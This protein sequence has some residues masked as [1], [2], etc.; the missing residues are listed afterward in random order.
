[1]EDLKK[2]LLEVLRNAF[3]DEFTSRQIGSDLDKVF[4]KG[5]AGGVITAGV[6]MGLIT[7]DEWKELREE[8]KESLKK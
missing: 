1:M 5:W 3:K 4:D 7:Y 6:E 8:V 2:T